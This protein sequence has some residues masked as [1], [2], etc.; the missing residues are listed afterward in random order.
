M[1]AISPPLILVFGEDVAAVLDAI[2][3]GMKEVGDTLRKPGIIPPIDSSVEF[4]L[5][6]LCKIQ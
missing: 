2:A 3:D 1:Q 6:T 4:P 5:S